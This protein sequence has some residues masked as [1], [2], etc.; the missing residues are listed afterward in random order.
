MSGVT[1]Q[2]QTD[3]K[4]ITSAFGVMFNEAQDLENLYFK[5]SVSADIAA[6]AGSD[7]VTSNTQLT[8]D[9]IITILTLAENVRKF[10]DNVAVSTADYMTTCQD[11]RYGV[12]AATFFNNTVE[13]FGDRGVQFAI[14]CV[15][16]FNRGRNAENVYNSTEVGAMI[17]SISAHRIVYGSDMTKDQLTSAITLVQ[18][19]DDFL[20]N[21]APGTADRKVTIGKWVNL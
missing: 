1:E 8:K 16:Q 13:N 11:V 7:A 6:S 19:W 20:N 18:N 14:D 5:G 3:L 9:Q 4:I 15:T 21:V 2:L 12:A 10:F 17:G